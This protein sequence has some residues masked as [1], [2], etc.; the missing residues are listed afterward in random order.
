MVESDKV[1]FN[2]GSHIDLKADDIIERRIDNDNIS[3]LYNGDINKLIELLSKNCIKDVTISEPSL[4]EIFMHY[5]EKAG[6]DA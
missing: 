6:E 5:Y 3:F 2:V 4:E 1:G